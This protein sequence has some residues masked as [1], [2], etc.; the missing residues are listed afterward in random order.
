MVNVIHEPVWVDPKT[1]HGHGLIR[2]GH[3]MMCIHCRAFWSGVY[4]KTKSMVLQS[5]KRCLP[6]QGEQLRRHCIPGVCV[7]LATDVKV[8]GR[9]KMD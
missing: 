7:H 5:R 6:T 2:S 4:N 9:E 3:K 8:L 1:G